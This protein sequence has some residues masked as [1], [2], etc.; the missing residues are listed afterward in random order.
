MTPHGLAAPKLHPK[1]GGD[2]AFAYAPTTA[3]AA[4]GST[5]S[6]HTLATNPSAEAVKVSDGS[7]SIPKPSAAAQEGLDIRASPV[8]DEGHL[9]KQ[10]EGNTSSTA[11][12]PAKAQT[13]AAAANS[14]SG[15]VDGEVFGVRAGSFAAARQTGS[16]LEQLGAARQ[17]H[18]TPDNI[19]SVVRRPSAQ[20]CFSCLIFERTLISPKSS[21]HRSL[22]HYRYKR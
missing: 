16:A 7:N 13:E 5:S 8:N 20:Q 21:D 9:L 1:M 10:G 2:S 17:Q 15:S 11:T 6:S 12:P 22:T 14:G 4:K 3:A 19:D 18:V